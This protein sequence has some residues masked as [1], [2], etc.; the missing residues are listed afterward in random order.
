MDR[1]ELNTPYT[2]GSAEEYHTVE[3]S[4]DKELDVTY[5]FCTYIHIS[6]CIFADDEYTVSGCQVSFDDLLASVVNENICESLTLL[7]S[8]IR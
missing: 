4:Y 8:S 2:V 6:A 7:R 3:L 5:V 1:L